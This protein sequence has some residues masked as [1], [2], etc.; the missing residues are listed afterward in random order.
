M[1]EGGAAVMIAVPMEFWAVAIDEID[2]RW[3]PSVG[4]W[5]AEYAREPWRFWAI[6]AKAA[7]ARGHVAA[8]LFEAEVR[9]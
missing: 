3:C 1:K 7:L 2:L 9:L 6:H 4:A 8:Q 5:V